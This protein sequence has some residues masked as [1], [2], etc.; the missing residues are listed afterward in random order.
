MTFIHAPTLF[1]LAIG[2]GMTF[3]DMCL[4]LYRAQRQAEFGAL[5]ELVMLRLGSRRGLDILEEGGH[6]VV[7]RDA[8]GDILDI[9]YRADLRTMINAVLDAGSRLTHSRAGAAV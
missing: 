9:S 1:S 3:L 2:G 4:A 7:S 5:E 8:F 6:V